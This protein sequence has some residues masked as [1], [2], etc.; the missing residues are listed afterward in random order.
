MH[1]KHKSSYCNP[2][3][4]SNSHIEAENRYLTILCHLRN[5][6]ADGREYVGIEGVA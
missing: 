4:D 6:F 1:V 5:E 2:H 3:S